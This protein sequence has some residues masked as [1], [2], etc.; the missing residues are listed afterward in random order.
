MQTLFKALRK[1]HAD[2]FLQIGY[3]YLHFNLVKLF[4]CL[5]HAPA[6]LYNQRSQVL[7]VQLLYFPLIFD[8][9][10]PADHLQG[11][12][13]TFIDMQYLLCRLALIRHIPEL[14]LPL[15]V[16]ELPF[17]LPLLFSANAVLHRF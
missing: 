17:V 14:H 9:N 12:L 15:V 8:V 10:L 1:E 6:F 16:N 11:L 3:Q 2:V 5:M 7:S 4:F 13:H